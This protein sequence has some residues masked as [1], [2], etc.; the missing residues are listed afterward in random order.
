M[1]NALI[2]CHLQLGTPVALQSVQ[3]AL[4][5]HKAFCFDRRFLERR[6]TSG[7]LLF[8]PRVIRFPW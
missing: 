5:L 6:H 3:K 8:L 4:Y 7:H 2:S 1:T